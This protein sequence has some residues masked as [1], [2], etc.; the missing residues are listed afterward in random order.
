MPHK[1]SS[2]S[3]LQRAQHNRTF[4][5]T[6]QATINDYD[7]WQVIAIFYAAIHVLQAYFSAK[8]S[9]YPQTHQN[10]DDLLLRDR[11]LTPIYKEYRELKQL[12]VSC[13][14]MCWPTNAHDVSSAKSYLQR[15][16]DHIASL[17]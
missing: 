2:N 14:Y 1:F 15:I 8:T 16:E 17:L 5:E 4:S 9:E 6:V 12:S 3:H 7:D 13:R 10:R 11:N